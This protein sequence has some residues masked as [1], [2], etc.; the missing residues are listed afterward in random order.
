MNSAMVGYSVKIGDDNY[1]GLIP[2]TAFKLIKENSDKKFEEISQD[3][4]YNTLVKKGLVLALSG[5][6]V[7]QF[8]I[9]N[10]NKQLVLVKASAVFEEAHNVY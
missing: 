6:P 2:T 4:F 3:D 7:S 5:D 1:V 10:V 9:K 8:K